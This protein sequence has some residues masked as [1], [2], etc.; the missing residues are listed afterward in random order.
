VSS[1]RF[2]K[3]FSNGRSQAV[4]LPFEFRFSGGRVR[5]RRVGR[6]VLLEPV[7]DDPQL[8]FDELDAFAAEPFMPE[9]R[10][11]PPTQVRDVFP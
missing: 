10:K 7:Q 8:W 6:G 4:R 9:G 11:Q 2:A 1:P 3:L 5:I